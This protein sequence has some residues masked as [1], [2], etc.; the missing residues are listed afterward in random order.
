MEKQGKKTDPDQGPP[1]ALIR[2]GLFVVKMGRRTNPD[3]GAD[4]RI[5]GFKVLIL[6]VQD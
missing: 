5:S 4:C 6:L 1:R 2:V 3:Q